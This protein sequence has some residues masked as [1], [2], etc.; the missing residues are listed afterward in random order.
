MLQHS[1][2][3]VVLATNTCGVSCTVQGAAERTYSCTTDSDGVTCKVFFSDGS[4]Y[5]DKLGCQYDM[6]LSVGTN[7][8]KRQMRRLP[9]AAVMIVALLQSFTVALGQEV[10]TEVETT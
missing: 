10:P 8:D 5:V 6:S 2:A 3:L 4:V 7:M 9:L 1:K